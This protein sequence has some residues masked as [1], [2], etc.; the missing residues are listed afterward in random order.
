MS[1]IVMGY[2]DCKYCGTIKIKGTEKKCPYCGRPKDIKVKHY[3]SGKVEYLSEDEAKNYGKG[4]DWGCS[5]CDSVNSEKDTVCKNCGATREKSSKHY[6]E[7]HNISSQDVEYT[8]NSKEQTVRKMETP[9][10]VNAPEIRSD[11]KDN[12]WECSY[13]GSMNKKTEFECVQCG[14]PRLENNKHTSSVHNVDD[15]SYL[16]NSSDSKDMGNN[17]LPE[18]QSGINNLKKYVQDNLTKL[19]GSAGIFLLAVLAIIG[20]VW[21]VTPK[22]KTIEVNETNWKYTVDVQDYKTYQESDWSIPSGGR[23][24]YSQQEIRSYKQVLDHYETKT[25]TYTEQVLD[26]YDTNYYYTDNGDGTFTEHSSDTPVYRTETKTETYEEPVYRD[27]PVYDTKYYYEIERWKYAR[28][29]VATGNDKKPY[30]GELNLASNERESTKHQY[31]SLTGYVV[32]D[33]ETKTFELSSDQWEQIMAGDVV[34]CKTSLEN[35]VE[36]ISIE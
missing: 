26:H 11:I 17:I 13:C 16:D 19:L 6:F 4:P 15:S 29:V 35:I 24:L 20:I 36:I 25:R 21:L 9:K 31:Y 34:K 2:F 10:K 5:F 18:K 33:E 7:V 12:G 8:R 32:E 23:L 3:M 1:K 30:Y 28:S 14:A 27:E 22:E